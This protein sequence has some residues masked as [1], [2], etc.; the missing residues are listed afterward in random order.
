LGP[1]LGCF[2]FV[3]LPALAPSEKIF[4]GGLLYAQNWR[5]VG[6]ADKRTHAFS[7]N[8]DNVPP[9]VNS[10]NLVGCEIEEESVSEAKPLGL[11]LLS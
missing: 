10:I 1:N 4:T 2:V 6:I 11:S 8:V 3:L 5:K 7:D 9:A